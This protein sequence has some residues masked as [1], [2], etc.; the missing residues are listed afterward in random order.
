MDEALT[1]ISNALSGAVSIFSSVY[2]AIAGSL[3][4]VL[5]IVLV[6]AVF[7]FIILPFVG[8]AGSSDKAEKGQKKGKG[9]GNAH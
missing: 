4:I 2:E 1:V 3:D 8:G 7:R 9:D 6:T 5:I